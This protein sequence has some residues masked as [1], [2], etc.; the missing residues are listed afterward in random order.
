MPIIFKR[1]LGEPRKR[2]FASCRQT[3][4]SWKTTEYSPVYIEPTQTPQRGR[5]TEESSW[6]DKDNRYYTIYNLWIIKVWP[7]PSSP[8][9]V[10]NSN[11]FYQYYYCDAISSLNSNITYGYLWSICPSPSQEG[12]LYIRQPYLLARVLLSLSLSLFTIDSLAQPDGKI[13][14]NSPLQAM[15]IR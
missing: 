8:F 9:M 7:E 10:N 12:K 2:R 15:Q 14:H 5:F 3:Y 13:F 6:H 4:D 11:Y 1:C